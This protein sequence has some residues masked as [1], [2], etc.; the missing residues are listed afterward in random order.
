MAPI[1]GNAELR[2][3]NVNLLSNSTKRQVTEKGIM[4]NKKRDEILGK[5]QDMGTWIAFVL[6]KPCI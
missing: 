6:N 3:K 5:I 2:N 1:L 4:Q